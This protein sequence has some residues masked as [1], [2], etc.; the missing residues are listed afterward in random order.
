MRKKDLKTKYYIIKDG[1]VIGRVWGLD[2]AVKVCFL[3]KAAY[4]CIYQHLFQLKD[5]WFY[6][7]YQ[8]HIGE[9]PDEP[10]VIDEMARELFASFEHQKFKYIMKPSCRDLIREM[11][12]IR[13]HWHKADIEAVCV[14]ANWNSIRVAMTQLR[15]E[16]IDI[17]YFQDGMYVR[18]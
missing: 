13:G 3:L 4:A 18:K 17:R 9:L 7:L 11:Y 16:G 8:D 1:E 2:T 10:M 5:E 12:T 15:K 6:Q 14:G